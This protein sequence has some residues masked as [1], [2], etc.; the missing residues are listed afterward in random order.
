MVLLLPRKALAKVVEEPRRR[1]LSMAGGTESFMDVTCCGL[2]FCV[3][4]FGGWSF[5]VR[6]MTDIGTE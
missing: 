1:M 4:D 2:D 3:A 5:D 6:W